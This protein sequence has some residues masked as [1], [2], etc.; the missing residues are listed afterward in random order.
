ML[1]FEVRSWT[2]TNSKITLISQLFQ[3]E[4]LPTGFSKYNTQRTSQ[5]QFKLDEV[6]VSASWISRLE[7]ETLGQYLWRACCGIAEL[8]EVV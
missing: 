2:E 4:P 6:A 1:V 8:W 7:W 5:D 3:E